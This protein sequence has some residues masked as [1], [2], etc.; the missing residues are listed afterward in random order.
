MF[1]K[2]SSVYLTSIKP[3]VLLTAIIQLKGFIVTLTKAIETTAPSGRN[4]GF[5][6]Y[7]LQLI[8]C[9]IESFCL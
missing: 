5:A 3:L 7:P 2:K 4:V 8:S 9:G 1:R 6:S